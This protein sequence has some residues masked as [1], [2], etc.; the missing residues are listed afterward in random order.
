MLYCLF[1]DLDQKR[2][3]MAKTLGADI[4][5]QVQRGQT[6]QEVAAHVRKLLNKA[7]NKVIECT[8]AESSINTGIFVSIR[9]VV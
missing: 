6:A 2:L 8:G 5:I 3:E 7:P 4:T 1:L 9:R